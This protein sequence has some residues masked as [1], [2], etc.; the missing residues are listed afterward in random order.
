MEQYSHEA[1]AFFAHLHSDSDDLPYGEW[2]I[3][4]KKLERE[5]DRAHFEEEQRNASL[6]LLELFEEYARQPHSRA[7][8]VKQFRA[9]IKHFI[10]FLGH[11]NAL[12]VGRAQV[13]KWRDHLRGK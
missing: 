7:E 10:G 2:L 8:T 5:A 11:D 9:V 1:D 6:S 13:V 4:R 12:R 3:Q